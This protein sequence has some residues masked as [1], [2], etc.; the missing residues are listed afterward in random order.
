MADTN[1]VTHSLTHPVIHTTANTGHKRSFLLTV[2]FAFFT[3]LAAPMLSYGWDYRLSFNAGIEYDDN[4]NAAP[5]NLEQDE[6]ETSIGANFGLA[7]SSKA[8]ALDMNYSG[9]YSDYKNDVLQTANQITGATDILW[10]IIDEALTWNFNH[11]I[12]E[13]LANSSAADTRDNQETRNIFSTGPEFNA[14]LTKVDDLILSVEYIVL[15]QD[16]A[17]NET[18]TQQTNIDSERTSASAVWAHSLS[19]VSAFS[20]GYSAAETRF[21]NDSDDAEFQRL[22]AGYNVRLAIGQYDIRLGANRSERGSGNDSFEGPYAD[23]SFERDFGEHTL[24]INVTH[25]LTDSSIG[26]DNSLERLSDSNFDEVSIVER[27]SLAI[28]YGYRSLCR[29]CMLEISYLFDREDFKQER[30]LTQ[31]TDNNQNRLTASLSYQ[32]NSTLS[33]TARASYGQTNFIGSDR[34]D[35]DTQFGVN[36]IWQAQ[37]QLSLI[38]SSNYREREVD[39]SN[40]NGDY[41]GITTGVRATYTVN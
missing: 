3:T 15:R 33:T 41:D 5:K 2:S 13:A 31:S 38:F 21:D 22:F 19:N 4:A 14:R 37:D 28:D 34:E 23:I 25:E 12:T 6:L 30:L 8:L 17:E 29:G 39:P 18:P 27:S 7:H 40:L 1:S 10:T 11:N 36:V 32:V 20:I 9:A 35:K 16:D 26:I 24:G